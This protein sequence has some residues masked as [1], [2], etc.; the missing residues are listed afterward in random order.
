MPYNP[1]EKILNTSKK[2]SATI[3]E[4]RF[5]HGDSVISNESD[6]E[7]TDPSSVVSVCA[8]NSE[9]LVQKKNANHLIF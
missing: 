4:H 6:V 8:P 2:R 1:N 3:C 9:P 7:L 5:H